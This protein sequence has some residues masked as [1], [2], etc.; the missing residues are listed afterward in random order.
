MPRLPCLGRTAASALIVFAISVPDAAAQE[1]QLM[2]T[3]AAAPAGVA[4]PLASP[5]IE[6]RAVALWAGNAAD[7]GVGTSQ[8]K[9]R[10]TLRGV[11]SMTALQ[12]DAHDRP[13]FQQ[14]EVGRQILSGHSLSL[15]A[16]GG[17]RQEW[18]GTRVFLTR[19]LTQARLGGGVLQGSLVIERATSAPVVH[20]RAD[21]ITT[22]GWARRVSDR[23]SVGVEGLGQDLE[24]FWDPGEAE[25]GAKLLVGPSFHARSSSGRWT[26]SVTAGPV[27]HTT[28]TAAPSQARSPLQGGRHFGMFA[29][30]TWIPARRR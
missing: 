2:F 10:W 13:A 19:V 29:C 28:S 18:D 20:D 25:G 11:T 9:S 23:F 3:A 30:G 22:V 16:G 5:V 8:S 14:I 21:V 4:A 7:F 1:A 6:E 12:V 24:G 17:V 15:A 27:I 26:A